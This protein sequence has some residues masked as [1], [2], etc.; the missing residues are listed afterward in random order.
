MCLLAEKEEVLG[1]SGKLDNGLYNLNVISETS[2]I[3]NTPNNTTQTIHPGA[4]LEK[5]EKQNSKKCHG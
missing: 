3:L 4:E 5:G 1:N 2:W